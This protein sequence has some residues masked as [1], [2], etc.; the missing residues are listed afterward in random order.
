MRVIYDP[1]RRRRVG[2]SLTTG[3]KRGEPFFSMPI[4]GHPVRSASVAIAAKAKRQ[5]PLKG[6]NEIVRSKRYPS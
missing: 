4:Y 2:P 5:S 1:F 6:L 3:A